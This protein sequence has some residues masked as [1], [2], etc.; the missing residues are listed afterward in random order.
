[1]IR[2]ECE[3]DGERMSGLSTG[4]AIIYYGKPESRIGV[5]I[6]YYGN[7]GN[8]IEN[9]DKDLK[10]AGIEPISYW[11]KRYPIHSETGSCDYQYEFY[12]YNYEPF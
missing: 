7:M 4:L 10:R 9:L 12:G 11:R 6:S 5:F 8:T 2:L 1:M 3:I